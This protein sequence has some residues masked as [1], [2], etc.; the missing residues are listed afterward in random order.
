MSDTVFTDDDMKQAEGY[1]VLG[2]AYFAARR[3]AE[4]LFAGD[5]AQPFR[6]SVLKA[7]ELMRDELY[8]YVEDYIKGD[9]E[10]NIGGHIKDMVD[11][12]VQAILTGEEWAL[13]L[14]PLSRYH[15]GEKIRAVVAAHCGES[16]LKMRVTELEDENK[17]LR[18]S[19]EWARR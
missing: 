19:L 5:N 6:A 10:T 7:T 1:D 17:R 4:A 18:E 9:L 3:A 12:T 11:R 14:Y 16:V 13:N 2:P 8:Q 15:D